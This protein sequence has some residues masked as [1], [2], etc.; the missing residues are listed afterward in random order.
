MHTVR[1]SE[2]MRRPKID[3]EREGNFFVVAGEK[4]G[5]TAQGCAVL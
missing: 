5:R 1:W 3:R 4:T 2:L